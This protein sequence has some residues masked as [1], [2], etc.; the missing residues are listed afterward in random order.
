MYSAKSEFSWRSNCHTE[1]AKTTYNG[2]TVDVSGGYHDAGRSCQ[3]WS[4]TGIFGYILGL[5]QYGVLP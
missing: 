3:V 4:A 1:D 2:K 5:A